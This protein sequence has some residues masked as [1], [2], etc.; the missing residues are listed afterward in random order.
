[1]KLTA[2]IDGNWLE[3]WRSF[4][5]RVLVTVMVIAFAPLL[6]ATV[7]RASP[8]LL[9]VSV[10]PRVELFSVI[11]HLAANPEQSKGSV[12]PYYETV[13]DEYFRSYRDHPVVALTARLIESREMTS[14]KW[15]DIGVLQSLAVHVSDATTLEMRVPLDPWPETLHQRWTPDLVDEFLVKAQDF[16]RQTEFPK[17]L[18]GQSAFYAEIVSRAERVLQDDVHLEWFDTFF[19]PRPNAKF[20]AFVSPLSM[21]GGFGFWI[22]EKDAFEA[23]CLTGILQSKGDFQRK[24][25]GYGAVTGIVHE[26]SHSYVN[27]AAEPYLQELTEAVDRMKSSLIGRFGEMARQEGTSGFVRESLVRAAVIR[28]HDS[29]SGYLTTHLHLG[30]EI[31]NGLFWM[32]ELLETLEVYEKRRD[33]NPDFHAYMPAIVEFFKDYS[34][35][36]ESKA[37]LAR[38]ANAMFP[39]YV[40]LLAAYGLATWISSRRRPVR[41][42]K[43]RWDWLFSFGLIYAIIVPLFEFLYLGNRPGLLAIVTGGALIMSAVLFMVMSH[44]RSGKTVLQGLEAR[45]ANFW[46]EL[47]RYIRHPVRLSYLFVL[48]GAPLFLSAQLAWGFSAL[49]V[50]ALLLQTRAR[51]KDLTDFCRGHRDSDIQM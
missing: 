12:A 7:V 38:V 20:S 28:Y 3:R 29:K 41:K 4:I 27:P 44:S 10:D 14:A 39:V 6:A 18:V 11:Y 21:L 34:M 19:G 45:H 5:I 47:Y 24:L 40:A 23:I 9:L 30:S 35:K 49:A 33:L 36:I 43:T 15:F 1:M 25:H 37:T 50:I 2:S 48:I 42:I 17:F 22:R 13:V 16:A 32:P 46:P 26:F 31:N 51:G 8:A